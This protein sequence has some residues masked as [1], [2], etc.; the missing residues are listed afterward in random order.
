VDF[1]VLVLVVLAIVTVAGSFVVFGEWSLELL[2]LAGS[3]RLGGEG[4]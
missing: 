1:E 4:E 3:G 2:G